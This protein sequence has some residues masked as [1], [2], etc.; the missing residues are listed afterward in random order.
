M[1][2]LEIGTGIGLFGLIGCELA[3]G[4]KFSAVLMTLALSIYIVAGIN[5]F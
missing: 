4:H 5:G 2:A 1:L 3:I